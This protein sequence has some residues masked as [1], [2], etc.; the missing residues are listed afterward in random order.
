MPG[1]P[2]ERW[3]RI[4]LTIQCVGSA[5]AIVAAGNTIERGI[6]CAVV[7]AGIAALFAKGRA[8]FIAVAVWFAVETVMSGYSGGLF[9][10]A[11]A[12]FAR[13]IRYLAPLAIVVLMQGDETRAHK[14]LIYAT[15]AVFAAHGLEALVLNPKFI[16][17]LVVTIDALL[18]FQL[19]RPTAKVML[20][21]IGLVDVGLAVLLARTRSRLV[22]AYMAFWGVTTALMRSVFY[23][24]ELG[25]HHS[26]V[27]VLNGGAPLLLL[28]APQAMDR[29]VREEAS[30]RA[31]SPVT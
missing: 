22:L 13:A 2:L 29:A 8:L 17:Y 11:V 15:S 12:P 4:G 23:G 6:A 27:R 3:L 7:L 20:F 10:G 5:G 19:P 24:P 18:A 16:D 9:A 1:F 21:A 28:L 14:L 31:T 25:W 26:V 30:V